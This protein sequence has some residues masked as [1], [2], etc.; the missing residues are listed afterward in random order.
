MKEIA[1]VART[2][3]IMETFDL[4]TKKMFG[5][6]FITEPGIVRKIAEAS[7]VTKE[8]AVIEIGPG[9][10]ALTEQLAMR[11]GKVVAF[12]VDERLEEVL[13]YSLAQYDNKEVIFQDFLTVDVASIVGK[14][15]EQY[16]NVMLSANL[17]Y[18]ITTPILFHIFESNAK[19]NRITVMMQ[20]EVADR[21]AAKPSTKDYNALS[22]ITQYLYEVSVVMK[23]P[24]TVFEPKPNVDS[25]VIQF[26]QRE[27]I[28]EVASRERFFQVV[29]AC[30]DQRRKTILNNYGKFLG[31]KEEA[32]RQ[33]QEAGI[34]PS[35]RAESMSLAEFLTLYRVY[36]GK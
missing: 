28:E 18:Y 33:L 13:A 21:F 20:K 23:V 27:H 26:V 36:E 25:A 11:A 31:N 9:I 15:R 5:Q 6:N 4:H 22:V 29:K 1:T 17:P 19:I 7:Q 24:R 2:K 34:E 3:E 8:D 10:G 12:E 16:R 30:F 32:S 14:L 35:R